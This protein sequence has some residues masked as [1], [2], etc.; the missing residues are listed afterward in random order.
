MMNTIN[1]TR[2]R[3][4]NQAVGGSICALD[5]S[6]AK[7]DSGTPGTDDGATPVEKEKSYK[8]QKKQREN[9]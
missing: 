5:V 1:S 8:I 4:P 6:G 3:A 7:P 2:V 9:V